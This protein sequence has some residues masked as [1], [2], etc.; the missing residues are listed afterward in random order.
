MKNFF[1]LVVLVLI[2]L[3]SCSQQTMPATY[4][5]GYR[6]FQHFFERQFNFELFREEVIQN[7]EKPHRTLISFVVTKEGIIDSLVV[8]EKTSD[9]L[10][11]EAVRAIKLSNGNWTPYKM[12]G[13]AKN[14]PRIF[15]PAHIICSMCSVRSEELFKINQAYFKAYEYKNL[16]G[17]Q[18]NSIVENPI[19]FVLFPTMK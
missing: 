17:W 14:S 19:G 2:S 15:L 11:A 4:T 12:A 10:A 3:S 7:S 8:H 9:E 1:S 18:A 5:K 16:P 6:N 13:S